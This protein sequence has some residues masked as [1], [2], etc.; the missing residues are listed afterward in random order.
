MKS[1][2]TLHPTMN[3]LRHAL[4]RCCH[5]LGLDQDTCLALTLLMQSEEELETMLWAMEKQE[6]MGLNWGTTEVV[7][8]ADKIHQRYLSLLEEGRSSKAFDRLPVRDEMSKRKRSSN[9]YN[10]EERG[11][12]RDNAGLDRRTSQG[13]PKQLENNDGSTEH[14]ERGFIKTGWD[15]TNHPRYMSMDALEEMGFDDTPNGEDIPFMTTPN[16]EIY[17]YVTPDHKKMWLDRK[18]MK[19]E[20]GIHEYTH[21]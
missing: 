3:T 16:G 11:T 9:S 8:M 10:I 18:A 13:E 15:G 1:S 14:T 12:D 7:L 4:N 21:L 19:P 17:G 5:I 6:E 20:H 2:E